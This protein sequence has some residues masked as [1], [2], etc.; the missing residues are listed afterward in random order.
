M[1]ILRQNFAQIVPPRYAI[2]YLKVFE[3]RPYILKHQI[4]SIRTPVSMADFIPKISVNI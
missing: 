4:T 2:L 3:I 1:K